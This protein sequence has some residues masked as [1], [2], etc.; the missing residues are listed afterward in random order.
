MS[1]MTADDMFCQVLER[2]STLSLEIGEA[3]A[4]ATDMRKRIYDLEQENQ[5]LRAQLMHATNVT[6]VNLDA[7]T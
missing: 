4:N 1:S 3:H 7:T 5:R 6:Q 2:L